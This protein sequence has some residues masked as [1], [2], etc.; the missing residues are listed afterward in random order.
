[1]SAI[2]TELADAAA[3]VVQRA[4]RSLVMLHNGRHGVGAGLIVGPA[5]DGRALIVTNQHVLAHSREVRRAELED[6]QMM[7]AW[8]IASDPEIDLA[9]LEIETDSQ[10]FARLADSRRLRVGD[11]VFAIGHPWGQPRTVTA[12]VVSAISKLQTQA[13]ARRWMSSVRM[14][15]LRRAILAGR[16][17]MQAARWLGST[18]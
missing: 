18:P 14:S 15:A 13:G 17:W 10:D 16:C 6:G 3:Q 5:V 7:P 9:L 4:S 11:L 1:M 2:S 8:R 12:G